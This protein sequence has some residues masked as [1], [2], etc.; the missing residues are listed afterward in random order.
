MAKQLTI[1]T[2]NT[3]GTGTDRIKYINKVMEECDVLCIQEHWLLN[4]Q[5]PTLSKNVLNVCI[6]GVSGMDGCNILKGRPYGGCAILWKKDIKCSVTPLI[7]LSNRVCG[8]KLELNDQSYFLYCVYM[9]VDG[10]N[11]DEYRDVLQCINASVTENNF[12]NIIIAG[13]FNTD[14]SRMNSK[15]TEVMC[16]FL[17]DEH[18][19]PGCTLACTKCDYTY[20][21]KINRNRSVIDHIIFSNSLVDKVF[22][23]EAIHDGDNLSD[24]CLVISKFKTENAV[25]RNTKKNNGYKVM[26]EKASHNGINQYKMR[27]DE[28]LHEIKI[29]WEAIKCTNFFCQEHS[30]HIKKYCES[31]EKAC[32]VSCNDTIP[33]SVKNTVHEEN[34]PGWNEFVEPERQRS[35]FWHAIWKDNGSPKTGLL[36]DIRRSTRAKYHLAVRHVKKNEDKI[37]AE[38]MSSALLNNRSRDFWKEVKCVRGSSKCTPSQIEGKTTSKDISELFAKKY[39][40]LYN[41]VRTD[42]TD[43]NCMAT[44]IDK[45]IEQV[46]NSRSCYSKHNV[47]V[48][49]VKQAL[50]KLKHY[51]HDGHTGLSSSNFKHGTNN[52]HLHLAMLLNAVLVHGVSADSLLLSV[53]VPI[54]KNM[55]KS[56]NELDNYRAIAL[57]SPISKVLDLILYNQNKHIFDSSQ[58]QFGYKSKLSTTKCTMIANEVV[59]YYLQNGS[60]VYCT[61]LDASKAFDRVH[62]GKLFEELL[63]KGLC[64]IVC[65]LLLLQYTTQQYCV[66]FCNELSDRFTV[67]NGVKQGGVLSPILFNIYMDIL[68]RK[69]KATGMGCYVGNIFA[70]ALCYA[71]DIILLTP[72][73]KAM[74]S[75]LS[76]CED[77]STDYKLMFNASKSKTIMFNSMSL[78]SMENDKFILSGKAIDIVHNHLHLGNYFG[79]NSFELQIEKNIKDLYVKF[80]LLMAQFSHVNVDTKYTLFKSF[81]LSV[82]GSQL[83]NC[84]SN[85]CEKFYV[86]WRKCVRKLFRLPRRAHSYLLPYVCEDMPIDTQLDCRFG[87]FFNSCLNCDNEVVRI[88][89][90]NALGNPKSNLSASVNVLCYKYNLNRDCQN[91]SGQIRKTYF[92]GINNDDM[93]LGNLIKDLL[94]INDR[95]LDNDIFDIVE[96]LCCS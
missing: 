36:A 71:D 83:W 70:G 41:S 24:H 76:V 73:R 62:Y 16:Q 53:M 89:A 50:S 9:P 10:Q 5:L 7:L 17:N 84:E 18:L 39:S 42:D 69:L 34:L 25:R 43:I 26:W 58:C 3:N 68:L 20:E 67:S 80:N 77:Y 15:N 55:K 22:R 35:L 14:L 54:P 88:V 85:S 66:S 86:A 51:K 96:Y 92:D 79:I 48:N 74:K 12:Q 30:E 6:H 13:D 4:D 1:G 27:L 38:R 37:K 33:N 93:R 90:R 40:E 95:H 59:S 47:N 19:V 8:I 61:L 46:C 49:D 78:N 64:P 63:R 44:E 60:P 2:L 29:P 11:D 75:F 82:Y 28:L 21:S 57:S 32:L 56:L 87:K 45:G 81:C 31:I 23:Y 94:R 72:S 65:K 91:F 52:L